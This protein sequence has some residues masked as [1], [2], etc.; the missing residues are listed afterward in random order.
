MEE[1]LEKKAAGV[2]KCAIVAGSA[3]EKPSETKRSK[4]RENPKV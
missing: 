2:K 1:L 4:S 3:F